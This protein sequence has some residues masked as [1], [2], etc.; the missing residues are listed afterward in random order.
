ML[1]PAWQKKNARLISG[2]M[3]EME[4]VIEKNKKL[5]GINKRGV[6]KYYISKHIRKK[7]YYE[8]L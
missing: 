7:L 5:M 1:K 3:Y 6:I 4:T 2:K 8:N